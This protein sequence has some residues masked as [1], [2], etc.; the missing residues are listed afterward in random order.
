MEV[1]MSNSPAVRSIRTRFLVVA[2]AAAGPAGFTTV[3]LLSAPEKLET[4]PSRITAVTVHRQHAVVT[5]EAVVE[6]TPGEH[7]IL[8]KDLPAQMDPA[9]VRVRGR[10][11]PGL[12]I[13]GVEVRSLH[14]DAEVSLE[15][16]TL[17]REIQELTRRHTLVLE[18]KKSIGILRDFIIGLKAAAV[19]TSSGDLL[20]RGFAVADWDHAVAFLSAHLDRLAEE[21]QVVDR[22]GADLSRRLDQARASLAQTASRRTPDRFAA[23]IGVSARDGGSAQLSMTYLISGAS[24]TPLYD[25]RLDPAPGRVTLEGLGQITQTTGEDWS[26]VTITLTTSQPLAGIDLPR[27]ASLR[28]VVPGRL[29]YQEGFARATDGVSISSESIDGLPILGRNYQ[30]VLT[31]SAGA[32]DTDGDGNPNIHGARDTDVVGARVVALPRAEATGGDSTMV[33]TLPGRLDIPSDGQPHQ[34]LIAS[35]EV[36]ASVEYHCVPAI[37]PEVYLVARFTLPDDFPLLPGRMAHFVEGD[38]VGHSTVAAHSG[39]EELTLSFGPEARLRAERRDT[40]LKTSRRG[41]EEERDRKVVTTLSNYLGRPTTVHLSDRVPISGDDRIDI[42][43]D[44]DETTAALSADPLEPGILRWNLDVP[45][46]GHA[47]VTLRYRIRVPAGLLP[48][49]R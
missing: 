4:T 11:T 15:T 42:T 5:R 47:D 24:W 40:L 46:A 19:E 44:R 27:L 34:H 6:M 22:D 33:Y 30:D 37:S 29:R 43:V 31:L 49:E 36:E 25:A 20:T 26:D 35:R 2:L 12:T 9:S 38:L 8:I 13:Q 48:A 10:G 17:E 16:Q 3:P 32:T 41:K 23:E 28:L 7:R 18:R 45:A 14:E 21:E 1:P 39:G